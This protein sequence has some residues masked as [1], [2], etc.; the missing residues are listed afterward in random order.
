MRFDEKSGDWIS[1]HDKQVR[2]RA[3]RSMLVKLVVIALALFAFMAIPS[4]SDG[5][6]RSAVAAQLP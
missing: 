4:R 3:S 6:R 2:V 5:S 1:L